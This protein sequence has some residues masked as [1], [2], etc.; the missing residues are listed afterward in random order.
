M[1]T[2]HE[3]F[4]WEI[5]EGWYPLVNKL[6]E[7]LNKM[8]WD[9]DIHQIKEKFGGLRFYIGNGTEEILDRIWKAEEES[10]KICEMCGEPG[11]LRHGGWK[12]TLCDEHEKTREKHISI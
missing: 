6:I 9:G 8:G 4:G 1:K 3:L 10:Y 2:P 12:K 7:D 11:K 5:A